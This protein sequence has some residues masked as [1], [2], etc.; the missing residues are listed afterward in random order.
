MTPCPRPLPFKLSTSPHPQ[1]TRL[2]P[3]APAEASLLSHPRAGGRDPIWSPCPRGENRALPPEAPRAMEGTLLALWALLVG[4]D[5][6]LL[7]RGP[8]AAPQGFVGSTSQPGRNL[9]CYRCFKVA[10]AALCAPT[11]C[12]PSDRVCVS[13]AVSF[14][15][16]P[17]LPRAAGPVCFR[18]ELPLG[19]DLDP[20]FAV[21][22][23]IRGEGFS[24]QAL[25]PPVPQRQRGA[26]VALRNPGFWVSRQH[27][28]ALL[29]PQPLQP[30]APRP[31]AAPGPAGGAA[32]PAGPRPLGG[33]A[34][35]TLPR[36]ADRAHLLSPQ[37][38]QPHRLENQQPR[39]L[40][41]NEPFGVGGGS[42]LP[43]Q[44][45]WS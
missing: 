23:R 11:A 25:R 37:G 10:S 18:S 2:L 42:P 33:P 7:R 20:D 26:R 5:A 41:G 31:G 4:W 12:S 30:G 35:S 9:T 13:H 15:L 16:R 39:S 19:S 38:P 32:A 36:P 44:G 6:G 3:A 1:T 14:F 21:T 43:V 34:V 45:F 8:G 28:S 29:Q 27:R 17:G 24:Q 40:M 22:G